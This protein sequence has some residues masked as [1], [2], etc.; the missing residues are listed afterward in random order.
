MTEKMIL[1]TALMRN[2]RAGDRVTIETPHGQRRT[3][4]AVMVGPAG[5]VLD[6]GG[7]H[8]TRAIADAFNIVRI[9]RAK[10]EKK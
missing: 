5:W 1:R 3:G 4:R 2:V 6:M 7:P 8:G 10:G 9:T